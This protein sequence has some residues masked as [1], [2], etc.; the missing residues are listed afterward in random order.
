MKETS[1]TTSLKVKEKWYFLMEIYT[2]EHGKTTKCME[3]DNLNGKMVDTLKANTNK[4]KKMGLGDFLCQMEGFMQEN[5]RKES[6][7]DKEST[8]TGVEN[9]SKGYGRMEK[10]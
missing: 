8:R 10:R 6:N 2:G 9:G 7:T 1:L 3:K 4:I 5:G